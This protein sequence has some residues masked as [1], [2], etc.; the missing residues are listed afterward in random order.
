MSPI[1]FILLLCVLGAVLYLFNGKIDP[2]L[3][4][5]IMVIIVVVAACWLLQ[6]FGIWSGGPK[7][8]APS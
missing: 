7:L 3:Y 2:T 1:E 6:A 8:Y 4:K 5:I